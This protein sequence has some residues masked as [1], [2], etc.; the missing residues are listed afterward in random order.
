MNI[1]GLM[2]NNNYLTILFP[3]LLDIIILIILFNYLALY[4]IPLIILVY[5]I[6]ISVI[7]KLDAK[8]D[9]I[10]E[11]NELATILEML[12]INSKNGNALSANID[13]ILN[14]LNKKSN[15]YNLLKKFRYKQKLGK[16]PSK[17]DQGLYLI[18]KLINEAI[19][20][21]DFSSIENNFKNIK[22]E[23]AIYKEE[24]QASLNKYLIL[25]TVFETVLPSLAIFSVISY[26]IFS[27]FNI[28]MLPFS[29][30]MLIII[31]AILIPILIII[32]DINE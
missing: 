24:K 32:D 21:N 15:L 30:F 7:K 19:I 31:P 5:W 11:L 16:L 26:A 13:D 14:R 10:N 27:N 17:I 6:V 18:E 29:F 2:I 1:S 22:Y 28:I 12:Y 23:L 3:F 4:F 9:K 8:R 20:N 25:S